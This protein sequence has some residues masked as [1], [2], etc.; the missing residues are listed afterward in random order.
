MWPKLL[1]LLVT[2]LANAHTKYGVNWAIDKWPMIYFTRP[3][4]NVKRRVDLE[5]GWPPK[6]PQSQNSLPSLL[7]HYLLRNMKYKLKKSNHV[8]K[9]LPWWKCPLHL[10]LSA[11]YEAELAV[12]QASLPMIFHNGYTLYVLSTTANIFSPYSTP[13]GSHVHDTLL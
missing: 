4:I 1:S 12:I 9:Y 13:M 7:E 11:H 5:E 8:S 3:S 6:L 10:Y 2:Q